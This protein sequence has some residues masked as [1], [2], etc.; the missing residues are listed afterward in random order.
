VSCQKKGQLIDAP[1]RSSEWWAFL[2]K[3]NGYV[4]NVYVGSGGPKL[5][6][7]PDCP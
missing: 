6:G 5:P 2:P 3:Y 7:V 4:T 1:P